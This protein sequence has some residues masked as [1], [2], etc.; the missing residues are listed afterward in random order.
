MGS[1]VNFTAE[2]AGFVV[3]ADGRK[4]WVSYDEFEGTHEDAMAFCG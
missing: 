1:M 3:E 2:E 4:L